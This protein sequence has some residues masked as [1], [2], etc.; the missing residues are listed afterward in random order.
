MDFKE[1]AREMLRENNPHLY[2]ELEA[3]GKLEAFLAEFEAEAGDLFARTIEEA[4]ERSPVKDYLEAAQ[5][6]AQAIA[7]ANSLVREQMIAPLG[8]RTR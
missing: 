1:E 2:R 7:A 4:R 6:D 8:R 5:R 3:S